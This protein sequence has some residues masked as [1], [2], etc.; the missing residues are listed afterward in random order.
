MSL[1]TRKIGD[2]DVTALG[3]GAMGIAAY[4]AT[5]IGEEERFKVSVI[6]SVLYSIRTMITPQL[7]DAVYESGCTNWDTADA[8]GDS[9]ISIGK[10]CEVPRLHRIMHI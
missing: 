6:L 5:T 8:Y 3:F 9:E 7:L 2:A 10:W 4:Y 1:P